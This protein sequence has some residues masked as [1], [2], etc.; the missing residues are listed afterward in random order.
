M[1]NINLFLVL[2]ILTSS[3]ASCQ[4]VVNL[5]NT[6]PTNTPNTY[7]KD[8]GDKLNPYEGTWVLDDGVSYIKIVLVKKV[9]FPVW[10]YFE[11]CIIGGFQYKKNGVEII[12]TLIDINSNQSDPIHYPI[13]GNWIGDPSRTPFSQYTSDNSY[14]K[15]SIRE[16]DCFSDIYVRRLTLNGQIAIQIFKRKPMDLHQVCNPV[17]PQDFH[18]LIKQ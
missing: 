16:N 11:D 15:L 5:H 18:Y 2:T 9:K 17:I 12:N 6:Y 8:I 4:T 3:L 10:Q 14:L 1:K 13:S 7:Y